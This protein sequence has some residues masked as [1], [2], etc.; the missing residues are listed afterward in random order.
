[1]KQYFELLNKY[2]SKI[3]VLSVASGGARREL[4]ANRFNGLEYSFFFGADKN[5][6]TI[7][8]T[9]TKGIFSEALTRQHHRFHKTMNHGE[10][11]CSWSHKLIYED[12][13]AN[14]YNRILIFEDDAVPDPVM[15]KQI[16]ALLQEIPGDCELL[17]WGW[18]KNGTTGIG[19][20]FKQLVYRLQHSM[21]MLKWDNHI[22]QRLYAKPFSKH[23]K[24]AG[25]HDYTYAYA[26]NRSAVE[27]LIKMQTPI[28]YIADNLLAYAAT[29]GIV[30]GYIAWPQVFLHDSL[31]DGTPRD[32]YIR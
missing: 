1:M 16:P 28:Q 13:L 7:E 5:E 21:G 3:Y 2:Y 23:L 6:F 19:T 26:V 29:K 27:K 11:A 9:E 32:S 15:M 25:F 18:G 10:I 24:K 31:P 14:H 12:M 22:I 30:N 17:M 8:E 20:R 4:F